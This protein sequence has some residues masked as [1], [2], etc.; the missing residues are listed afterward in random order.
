MSFSSF[1]GLPASLAHHSPALERPLLLHNNQ[2]CFVLVSLIVTFSSNAGIGDLLQFDCLHCINGRVSR[3]GP[4]P[5][6]VQSAMG[7]LQCHRLCW[8]R[9]IF[10]FQKRILRDPSGRKPWSLFHSRSSCS[11]DLPSC[12]ATVALVLQGSSL[13]LLSLLCHWWSPWRSTGQ[14]GKPRKTDESQMLCV[15]IFKI[16][17]IPLELTSI[18]ASKAHRINPTTSRWAS[19]NISEY[20][21]FYT[22]LMERRMGSLINLMEDNSS[23]FWIFEIS[24]SLLTLPSR[25]KEKTHSRIKAVH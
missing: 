15:S 10:F 5:K 24:S 20:S 9:D 14:S 19:R 21:R 13:P 3:M 7:I 25:S 17:F 6:H 11:G 23:K 8:Q 22:R 4:S 2:H 12:M 18:P 16:S 1:Q